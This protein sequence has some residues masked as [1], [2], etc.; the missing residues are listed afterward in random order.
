MNN[1]DLYFLVLSVVLFV[2]GLKAGFLRTFCAVILVLASAIIALNAGTFMGE[3]YSRIIA[4][5]LDAQSGRAL[6]FIIFFLVLVAL[7][8]IL[9]G[10]LKGLVSITILGPLDMW[11]GGFLGIVRALIIGAAVCDMLIVLPIQL[12]TREAINT[13]V[14]RSY[15]EQILRVTFPIALS[16][17]PAVQQFLAKTVVPVVSSIKP[18]S[19][20]AINSIV[21]ND[22]KKNSKPAIGFAEVETKS[23]SIEIDKNLLK[24]FTP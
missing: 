4:G 14:F 13:S 19:L 24:R 16:S 6:I 23:I 20:E 17:G 10:L 15:G 8:E 11:M 18:P 12:S 7:S 3:V 9:L 2:L 21:K 5:G 22:D 1:I